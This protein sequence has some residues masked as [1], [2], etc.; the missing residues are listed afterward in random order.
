M[1]F[2]TGEFMYC[3]LDITDVLIPLPLPRS[4]LAGV[5]KWQL[6]GF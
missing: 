6:S 1:P 3:E 2:H 5:D 4:P